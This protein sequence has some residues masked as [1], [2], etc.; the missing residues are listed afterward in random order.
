LEVNK[1]SQKLNLLTKIIDKNNFKTFRNNNGIA[2]KLS[3]FGRLDNNY[4]G[5]GLT[6]GGKLEIL[7]WEEFSKNQEKLNFE[8]NKINNKIKNQRF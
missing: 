8:V 2:M 6:N 5:K 1:L 7:I 3:N 4:T